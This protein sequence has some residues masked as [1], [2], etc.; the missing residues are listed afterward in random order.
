MAANPTIAILGP[1]LLGGS[2]A[3]ASKA[4]AAADRVHLW[5]RREAAVAQIQALG[6]ADL[7]STDLAEVVAD[8]KL[9]VLATPV[10]AM[11][12]LVAQL[13]KFPLAPETV[14]TDL[15][16]VKGGV[17]TAIDAL[18]S[19]QAG[20]SYV[21]SH[22]MAG[23][24]LAGLE[25]AAAGLF[26][27][28]ACV[29]TPGA[30]TTPESLQTVD[31]F[32]T[33]LGCVTATMRPEQHDE[34]VARISHLPHLAASLV[35]AA[36]LGDDP[37]IGPIAGA[38]M[39]DTTRVASGPPAMWAEILLENRKAILPALRGLGEQVAT[40][41]K[42]LEEGDPAKLQA[43]LQHAKDLRDMLPEATGSEHAD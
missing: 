11:P 24:E 2:V 40:A 42:L 34:A 35:A 25:H 19:D 6:I 14:I 17:V 33:T 28:A 5:A 23:K 18:L 10:G 13:L 7:A 37:S 9:I 39:R 41:L 27:G 43:M 31:E 38:G 36:A 8:A 29:I 21:G 4:Y 3:L 15:G 1:G 20:L 22:P 16:S 30:S 32:W 12:G 26:L